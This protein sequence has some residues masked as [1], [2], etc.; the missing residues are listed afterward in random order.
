M[1]NI[2]I[3]K[4][5]KTFQPDTRVLENLDLEIK[6][7]SFTVLLG[8][9]GC[10]KSTLL[11]LIAGLDKPTSG[12]I[13]LDGRDITYEEPSK[14]GLAMVFQN[15]ALYPHMTVFQ[16]VE[17]GLRITGVP[18]DEREARV[19]EALETVNL[20]DQIKKRP[21]QMSGGQRQRVAL[22]R[23]IVKKPKIFLMDEPLSNL[24]AKLRGQMRE[25][26]SELYRKMGTTFLYVTHDQVEAMSMG[27]DI[28][29]M[30]GGKVIQEGSPKEMYT[31]PNHSFV[32]EFIGSPPCNVFETPFGKAAIRCE[33]IQIGQ[34]ADGL[35]MEV[36]VLGIEQLGRESI[37]SLSTELGKLQMKTLC[38][39]DESVENLTVTLPYEKILC[40]DENGKR[41]ED[42]GE[43]LRKWK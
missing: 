26:I 34:S 29:L 14:R 20:V 12:S 27:T 6:D 28:V 41:M 37:Y 19:M 30:N 5:C 23:A 40:F 43:S 31:N 18:K 11:R 17:Y 22:A 10:G 7:G 35:C 1:S 8:P 24:D 39:W 33:D 3:S 21:S 4:L 32:A 36:Q 9:S 25:N 16:N 13:F 38:S 2:T 42:A 15:Y